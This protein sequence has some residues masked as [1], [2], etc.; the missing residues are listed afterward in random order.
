MLPGVPLP[1][2]NALTSGLRSHARFGEGIS[3][4]SVVGRRSGI[5]DYPR[6]SRPRNP[7]AK[8]IRPRANG[9][10]GKGG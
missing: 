7:A 9:T 8:S 6:S 1:K 3:R 5:S 2:P 4:I 10:T